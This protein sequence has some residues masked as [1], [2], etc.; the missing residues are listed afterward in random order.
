MFF[1]FKFSLKAHLNLSNASKQL[2]HS[3]VGLICNGRRVVINLREI[4]EIMLTIFFCIPVFT[5][6]LWS[7]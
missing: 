3:L 2:K 4:K 6:E 7:L 5:H 1:F